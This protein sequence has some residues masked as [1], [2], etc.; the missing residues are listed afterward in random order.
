[1]VTGKVSENSNPGAGAA[2]ALAGYEYQLN[3]SV[4]AALRILLVT[5]SASRLTLEPANEEDL[6]ADLE[7]DTIGRVAPSADLGGRCRLIMQV[8]LRSGEPW[9]VTDIEGLLEHGK[10]RT[11]AKEHLVDPSVQ[12]LLVT[13]ASVKGIA[14]NLM[15]TNFEEP[16]TG[17]DS[18]QRDGHNRDL[19]GF[20]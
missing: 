3:V 16:A 5:K 6:E 11:P 13:N 4:Y 7:E 15:V 1:V 12:F 17:K 14:R 18:F 9:S 19:G 20:L 2:A 8:K 10:E